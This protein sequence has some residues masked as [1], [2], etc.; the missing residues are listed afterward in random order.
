MVQ[1]PDSWDHRCKLGTF[2]ARDKN[3]NFILGKGGAKS[4]GKKY[5]EKKET[6]VR[7]VRIDLQNFGVSAKI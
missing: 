4:K 6:I 3:I 5:L 7:R 2:P 1:Q